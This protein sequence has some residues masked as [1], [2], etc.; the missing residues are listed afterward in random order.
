MRIRKLDTGVHPIAQVDQRSSQPPAA[1][2]TGP[3]SLVRVTQT[4][5]A[6]RPGM[7]FASAI[8]TEAVSPSMEG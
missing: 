3:T 2:S 8:S 4:A 6:R 1:W 7:V 5:S